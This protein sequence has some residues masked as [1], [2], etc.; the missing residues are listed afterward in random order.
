MLED[1][2]L[3]AGEADEQRHAR[4]QRVL[5]QLEVTDKE[6]VRKRASSDR[7]SSSKDSMLTEHIMETFFR[8][9]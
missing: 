7:T 8:Q 6:V 1:S 9:W 3:D 4:A 2:R 5:L